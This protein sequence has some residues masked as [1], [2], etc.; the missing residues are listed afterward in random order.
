MRSLRYALVL[1]ATAVLPLAAQRPLTVTG[2]Q[3]VTFGTLIPGF[4]TSVSRTDPARSGRFDL[5]GPHDT[6]GQVTFTLPS[7][8]TGPAGATLPLTFSGSDAGYSQSQ[9]IGSQRPRSAPAPTRARSPSTSRRSH[10]AD[11]TVARVTVRGRTAR[12]A[13]CRDRP[14]RGVHGCADAQRSRA[15]VQ[16]EPGAGRGR[17][18]V[19][20]R[21]SGDGL[22]RKH[23]RAD[24]RAPRFDQSVRGGLDPGVP[25]PA[26]G[27]AAR[28]PDHPPARESPGRAR[29][30]GI[31]GAPRDL[32]EGR[33]APGHGRGGHGAGQGRAHPRGAHDHRRVLPQGSGTYRRHGVRPAHGGRGGFARRPGSPDSAGQRGLYRTRARRAV[34][35]GRQDRERTPGADRRLLHDGAALRAPD[36]GAG[37]RSLPAALRARDGTRR[38]RSGAGPPESTGA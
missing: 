31:L 23:R 16:P 29:R 20:L 11:G 27:A 37:A 8:L 6:Q 26:H 34:R 38:S 4:P 22:R 25:A 32:R 19:L 10:E 1:T 2:I 33:T 13:G 17:H 5:G 7:V 12:R 14:A 21:L 18:F 30:R 9:N 28:A 24:G 35:L 15:A 36:R 3:S